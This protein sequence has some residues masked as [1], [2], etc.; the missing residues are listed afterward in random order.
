M[1]WD[2]GEPSTHLVR[3]R[4]L[5]EARL[6]R[7]RACWTTASAPLVT[8]RVAEAKFPVDTTGRRYPWPLV[9]PPAAATPVAAR[10]DEWASRC[11]RGRRRRC[12][13]RPRVGLGADGLDVRFGDG[14]EV[15]GGRSRLLGLAPVEPVAELAGR[16]RRAHHE[17]L[18]SLAAQGGQ[19]V[20]AS[21]LDALGHGDQAEVAAG[22]STE[23]AI[24]RSDSSTVMRAM[25]DLSILIS[26]MGSRRRWATRARCRS[27]R[28]TGA[29]PARSEHVDRR[30]V[31]SLMTMLSVSSRVSDRRSAPASSRTA[32]VVHEV[33]VQEVAGRQVDRH[34][35]V[36]VHVPPVA[37][38]GQR[39]AHHHHGQARMSPVCSAMVMNSS[40]RTRP[41]RVVPAHELRRPSRCRWPARPWAGSR[42]R[43]RRLQRLPQVR[44]QREAPRGGRSWTGS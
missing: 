25:N 28:R 32:D 2:F 22:A 40:G 26:P 11:R 15:V 20:P 35:Q 38:L 24:A 18:R 17:A 34:R 27:R 14:D 9:W 33:Q 41:R 44:R 43:A 6:R 36:Q 39:L 12:R 10:A 31:D 29:R 19:Q 7:W 3:G 21:G 5:A 30:A 4:R 16:E 13:P 42:H 23:R 1:I 37:A 8:A